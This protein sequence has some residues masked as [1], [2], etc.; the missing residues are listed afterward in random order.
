MR[1]QWLAV[2]GATIVAAVGQSWSAG[3]MQAQ[4][5]ASPA[6]AAAQRPA[7]KWTPPRTPDGH[8][9]LQGMY[10]IATMTPLERPQGITGLSISDAEAAALEKYEAQR[11]EKDL[12]PSSADRPAPEV[13]GDRGPTKSYLEGL[14]RAGGGS[15]GGYNLFW[16]APGS[17]V[18]KIDGQRRSSII[19]DPSDGHVPAMKAE[20]RRRNA[21]YLSVYT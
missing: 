18:V 9:D 21:A 4:A 16:L 13:G 19:V 8:V 15:V 11:N 7:K 17:Q 6:A 2:I 1:R 10:D 12:A 5:P 20:A 3:S 14:F